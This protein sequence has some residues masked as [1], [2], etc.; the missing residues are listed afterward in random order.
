M[1]REQREAVVTYYG[2]KFLP[3]LEAFTDARVEPATFLPEGNGD[4]YLQYNYI[5][6]NPNPA[7]E[8]RLLDDAGDGSFFSDVHS[9]VHPILRDFADE[10][11]YHDL[12]LISGSGKVVYTV[13]KEVDLGT[14]LYEGPYQNSNLAAVFLEAQGDSLSGEVKLV[15]FAHYAP[16]FGEPS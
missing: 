15:D 1:T 13:E 3:R 12:I 7:G 5:V 2:E 4:L 9:L 16:S 8:K 6:T 14:D 11:G 10:F